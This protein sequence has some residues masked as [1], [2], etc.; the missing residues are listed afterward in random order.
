M[1]GRILT[2][3]LMAFVMLIACF[4]AGPALSGEHPWDSDRGGGD[5]FDGDD[6]DDGWRYDTII[7]PKDSVQ[8]ESGP[9]ESTSSGT[10][11]YSWIT[12]LASALSFGF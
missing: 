10:I 11:W 4:A 9:T 3:V 7:V 12:G 6:L 5:D 1:N 2:A 8:I